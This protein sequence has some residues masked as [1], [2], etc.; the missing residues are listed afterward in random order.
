MAEP[1]LSTA[2]GGFRVLVIGAGECGIQ[3]ILFFLGA[4]LGSRLTKEREGV[5]GITGLLVAQGLKKAGIDHAVFESEPSAGH[6]RPREWSIGMHWS[7]PFLEKILP[8]DLWVRLK[9]AQ[10]DPFHE[11]PPKDIFPIL[12]SQTGEVLKNMPLPRTV[13]VSRRKMRTLCTE[14]I[15]I[16]YGKT[17]SDITYDPSGVGVTAVFADGTTAKGSVLVGCDGPRSKVR[18]LLVGPEK[19]APSMLEVTHNN[20]AIE[21]RDAEKSL[22]MRKVHPIFYMGIHPDGHLVFITNVPDRD[23]PETWRFQVVMSWVGFCDRELDDAGR[24]ALIKQRGESLAE[25]FRSAIMWIP[26]GTPVPSN[27]IGYW[28]TAPWDNRGGRATLAGDAAHPLPPHRGQGINHC[29]MDVF[30]LTE[31]LRAASSKDG[32]LAAALAAYEAEMVN[33]GADEVRSSLQNAQ[34]L[35]DWDKVRDSPLMRNSLDRK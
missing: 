35:Y 16:Q 4:W 1:R 15:D 20:M 17:L 13:R 29:V 21:Y 30:R 24:L 32:D 7:L 2:S 33:R 27:D 10:N 14:G 9:E 28:A 34:M 11:S 6:Y 3:K 5:T 25:P 23:K 12:N 31:A 26:D 19:A 22:F 8:A 18:E